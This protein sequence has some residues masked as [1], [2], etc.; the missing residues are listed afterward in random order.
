MTENPYAPPETSDPGGI[1][2]APKDYGWKIRDGK[3]LV[4]V[5]SQLPMVDPF[6]GGSD[7]TMMLQELK[8]RHSPRWLWLLP[9]GG[10]LL[11]PMLSNEAEWAVRA[12]TAIPGLLLGHIVALFIGAFRA[13]CSV[14]MF[15]RKRTLRSRRRHDRITFALFLGI[16]PGTFLFQ[17]GPE[18]M[19]FIP[20]VVF[21]CWLVSILFGFIRHRRL[22][23]R[24]RRDGFFEITGVHPQA[25]REFSV[26]KSKAQ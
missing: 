18:W 13:S 3:L 20:S 24:I 10:A 15:I 21:P 26:M 23:C 2:N 25:I 6:V 1:P 16:L 14:R 8:V 17:L 11:V 22:K 7:E 19:K 4:R 12:I 9:L 5:A